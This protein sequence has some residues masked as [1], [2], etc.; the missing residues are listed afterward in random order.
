VRAGETYSGLTVAFDVERPADVWTLPIFTISNS[1]SG[2]ERNYQG[3]M[4]VLRWA[5]VVPAGGS[6]EQTTHARVEETP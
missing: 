1:E 4:L 3:A 6:W 2:F 5:I